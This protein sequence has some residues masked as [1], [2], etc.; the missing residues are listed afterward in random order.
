MYLIRYKHYSDT[1][2]S[3]DIRVL[4]LVSCKVKLLLKASFP[5]LQWSIFWQGHFLLVNALTSEFIRS[6][7]LL[8][9]DFYQLLHFT[10]IDKLHLKE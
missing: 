8:K 2:N 4:F 9:G 3:E 5:Q 6:L 10:N 1:R 7:Q